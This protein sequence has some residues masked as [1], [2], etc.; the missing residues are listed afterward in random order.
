MPIYE[1]RCPS[2]AEF[3]LSLPISAETSAPVRCPVCSE[4]SP[5]VFRAPGVARTPTGLAT[6]RG[7]EEAS[8]DQPQVVR[9]AA[10]PH[11]GGERSPL[12]AKPH[13]PAL[14]RP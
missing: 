14:P 10:T 9:R 7:P 12:R 6:A 4:R 2:C 1:F 3:R 13:L 11:K 5:R 8:R